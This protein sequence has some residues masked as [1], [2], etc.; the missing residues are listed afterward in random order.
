MFPAAKC[1]WCS[2][3]KYARKSLRPAP[4]L[5]DFLSFYYAF[6]RSNFKYTSS[7]VQRYSINSKLINLEECQSFKHVGSKLIKTYT[8]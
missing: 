3:L 1:G 8:G 5:H 2:Q 6:L 7:W 4:T